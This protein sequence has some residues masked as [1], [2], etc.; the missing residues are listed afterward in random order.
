MKDSDLVVVQQCFVQVLLLCDSSGS[1]WYWLGLVVLVLGVVGWFFGCCCKVLLLLLLLCDGFDGVVFVVVVL[2]VDYVDELVVQQCLVDEDD[3]VYVVVLD[4]VLLVDDLCC[5]LVF[6]LVLVIGDSLVVDEDEVVVE[7]VFEVVLVL[8]GLLVYVL[9]VV[10]QLF[11]C[12]VFEYLAELVFD[13][14]L[15]DIVVVGYDVIEVGDVFVDGIVFGF[16]LGCDCLELVIVYL[17]LGDVEI[18]CMLL[19]EVVVG[20]DLYMQ[21]EVCEL[22]VCLG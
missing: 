6:V 22:L 16:V 18:V 15:M 7:V 14:D 2:V 12:G 4:E 11:F 5:E 19:Q 8:L 3:N 10:V 21:V 13:V 17:D 1:G 9:E 20:V